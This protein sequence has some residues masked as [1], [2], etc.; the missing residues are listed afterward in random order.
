MS[1]SGSG[2]V[3]C[4]ECL[5][6]LCVTKDGNGRVTMLS[7]WND[8]G[9][10]TTVLDCVVEDCCT[11]CPVIIG[12]AVTNISSPETECWNLEPYQTPGLLGGP[13][14]A[15]EEPDGCRVWR[16]IEVGSCLMYFSGAV[17]ESGTLLDLPDNFCS[18][19]PYDGFM[20]LQCGCVADETLTWPLCE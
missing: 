5:P 3:T 7:F 12:S 2:C 15:S 18:E 8:A 16:L 19:Y 20:Q 17:S 10:L 6:R 14:G 11:P 1:G 13:E 9:T 4:E